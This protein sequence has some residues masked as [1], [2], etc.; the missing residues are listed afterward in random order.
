MTPPEPDAYLFHG[1]SL[2]Q[3][4]SSINCAGVATAG[5]EFRF[6]FSLPTGIP[7]IIVRTAR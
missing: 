2:A 3:S 6:G 5:H 1:K 7:K 4:T